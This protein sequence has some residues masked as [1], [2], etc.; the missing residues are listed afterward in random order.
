MGRW[1]L[2]TG[3]RCREVAAVERWL[4]QRGSCC[5]E[6]AAVK[7]WLLWRGGCCKEVAVVE[8]WPLVEVRLTLLKRWTADSLFLS[9]QQV[10]M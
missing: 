1:L 8:R 6:V 3:G 5:R 2:K 7:R 9:I 10:V 4:L